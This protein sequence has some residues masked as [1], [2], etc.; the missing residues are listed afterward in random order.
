LFVV[1]DLTALWAVVEIDE[2]L[3]SHVQAGRSIELQ[4]AA[5][6]GERFSGR[7]QF[8]GDV[9]NP[10]TRRITIRCSVPNGDGRLKPEMFASVR[11]QEGEVRQLVAVPVAAVQTVDG[12]PIVFTAEA[13]GRFRVHRVTTGRDADGLLEIRTG[14]AA[15]DP[16]VVQNAFVLKSELLRGRGQGS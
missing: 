1:S 4:V 11:V 15:G 3:L 16:V 13:E 12:Q 7:V 9:V 10:K 14:L 8:V 5:Y 6:P 2:S